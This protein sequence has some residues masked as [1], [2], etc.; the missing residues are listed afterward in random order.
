MTKQERVVEANKVIEVISRHG[1]RFFRHE[2]RVSRFELDAQGRVWLIDK[3][4]NKR[5]YTHYPY[6]WRNFTEGG[7]LKCLCED[8]RDYIRTGTPIRR[9]WFGPFPDWRCEGD[10]WGYGAKGMEA[11]RTDIAGLPAV[12]R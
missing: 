5:V 2:D 7:T 8:L 1:R 9:A 11:V 12:A 6:R 3:Y 10:P 4:S